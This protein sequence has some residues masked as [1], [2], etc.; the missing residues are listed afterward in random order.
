MC[1]IVIPGGSILAGTGAPSVIGE[2]ATDGVRIV[3][4]DGAG[5]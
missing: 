4:V 5:R 1:N 2:L 3:A